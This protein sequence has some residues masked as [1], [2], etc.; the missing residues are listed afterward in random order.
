MLRWFRR[1]DPEDEFEDAADEAPLP[2]Q[3]DFGE[4]VEFVPK[5]RPLPKVPD[6]A[7]IVAATENNGWHM[8]AVV[9]EATDPD[10]YL[11]AI[12][13][14]WPFVIARPVPSTRLS[15]KRVN[16]SLRSPTGSTPTRKVVVNW[17]WAKLEESFSQLRFYVK[18]ARV[19]WLP[20]SSGVT[21]RLTLKESG[22][23]R[24]RIVVPVKTNVIDW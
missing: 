8:A 16:P 2:E 13:V 9:T 1:A 21:I 6:F 11:R 3:I 22:Y 5:I 20:S 14:R 23:P 12:T 15:D 10:F 24:R 7:V 17:G 18:R 19:W 4:P